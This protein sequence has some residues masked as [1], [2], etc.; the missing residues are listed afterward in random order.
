MVQELERQLVG[1]ALERHSLARVLAEERGEGALLRQELGTQV[2]FGSF[3]RYRRA[4]THGHLC[5]HA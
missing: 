2:C 1:A 5:G 3:R 4:G